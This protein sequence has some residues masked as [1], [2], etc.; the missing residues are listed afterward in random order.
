MR[1]RTVYLI[2]TGMVL[3]LVAFYIIIMGGPIPKSLEAAGCRTD[4][5]YFLTNNAYC[6]MRTHGHCPDN[7]LMLSNAKRELGLCLCESYLLGQ[8]RG[9]EEALVTLIESDEI[10]LDNY[11][12]SKGELKTVCQNR[13]QFFDFLMIE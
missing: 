12:Q 11:R 9:T 8:T 5:V 7:N 1:R 3:L 10:L 4:Y 2:I 13:V 6:N